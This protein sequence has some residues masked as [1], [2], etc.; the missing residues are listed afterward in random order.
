MAPNPGALTSSHPRPHIHLRVD[1]VEM[2]QEAKRKCRQLNL[3]GISFF[4]VSPF[5]LLFPELAR[6]RDEV[7]ER[8]KK[9]K[10]AKSF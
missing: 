5:K 1:L 10:K 8:K 3:E 2:R 4:S 6:V 7:E 9:N